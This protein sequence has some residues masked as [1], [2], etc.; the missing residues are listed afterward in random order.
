MIKTK[1]YLCTEVWWLGMDND[2]ENLI[3]G[4]L[5]CLST[6]SAPPPAPSPIASAPPSISPWQHIHLD[7]LGPYPTGEISLVATCA[8]TRHIEADI[9]TNGTSFSKLESRPDLMFARQGYCEEIVT[10]SGPPFCAAVNLKITCESETSGFLIVLKF[11]LKVMLL[12][13]LLI[14]R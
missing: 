8:F 4:C 5:L 14:N 2:V 1:Q 7:F 13:R 10:D 11:G 6:T 12:L 3:K 9:F